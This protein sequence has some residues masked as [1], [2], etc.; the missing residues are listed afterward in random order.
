MR[1]VTFVRHGQSFAN[2][3]G[4]TMEHAAI[5]LTELGR[6]QAVAVVSLL[7]PSP[8]E[9]LSSPFLRAVDTSRPYCAQVGLG[10][11][12]LADLSELD[13]IDADLLMGLTGE[14]RRPFGEAY[15]AEADPLR[16]MG[17]RAE[18]FQEFTQRVERFRTEQMPNLS[19]QAVVFGHGTWMAML[20]WQLQGLQVRD[21]A[22]MKAFRQF[23]LHLPMPNAAVYRFTQEVEG[24]DW[25]GEIDAR[26]LQLISAEGP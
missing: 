6:Q 20:I 26:S 1:T 13:S 10:A 4:V 19:E 7:P 17:P 5:P 11:R 9:V 15:W 8:T 21:G 12:Q 14:Q 25:Q 18:T 2:A 22:D 24:G 23:H 3:G 16:R